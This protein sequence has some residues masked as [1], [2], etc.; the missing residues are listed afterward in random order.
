MAA[1]ETRFSESQRVLLSAYVAHL[2]GTVPAQ[3][4]PPQGTPAA[5]WPAAGT[6]TADPASGPQAMR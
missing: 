2:R 4:K 3:P 5:P 1:W 6:V